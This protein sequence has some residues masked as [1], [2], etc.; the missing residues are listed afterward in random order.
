MAQSLTQLVSTFPVPLDRWLLH[1]ADGIVTRLR[2][3]TPTFEE[4]YTTAQRKALSAAASADDMDELEAYSKALLGMYVLGATAQLVAAVGL[5]ALE[6]RFASVAT[7]ALG[8]GASVWLTAGILHANLNV[9]QP[10]DDAEPRRL[11]YGISWPVNLVILVLVGVGLTVAL[12][13]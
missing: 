1:L 10:H 9:I 8:L 13:G 4:G 5:A 11:Q 12:V 2:P 6:S 3:N 7:L